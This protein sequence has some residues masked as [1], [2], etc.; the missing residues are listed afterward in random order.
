MRAFAWFIPAYQVPAPKLAVAA[1]LAPDIQ[2]STFD[3]LAALTIDPTVSV[4]PAS[5]VSQALPEHEA[6]HETRAFMV[7]DSPFALELVF[8]PLRMLHLTLLAFYREAGQLRQIEKLMRQTSERPVSNIVHRHY[9]DGAL[10]A[11]LDALV[12]FA[13]GHRVGVQWGKERRSIENSF[14]SVNIVGEPPLD[15][16][17]FEVGRDAFIHLMNRL[18]ED[19]RD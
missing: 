3:T 4:G 1:R 12:Y 13:L 18:R 14:R 19:A 6:G 11:A 5:A 7:S 2:R 8:E 9:G 15:P 16:R 17:L 10:V